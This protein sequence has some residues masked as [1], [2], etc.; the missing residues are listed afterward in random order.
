[1]KHRCKNCNTLLAEGYGEFVIKCQRCKTINN[2]RSLKN[3]N[4]SEHPKKEQYGCEYP[5]ISA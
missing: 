1:M 3:Q 2:C 5:K 4:A